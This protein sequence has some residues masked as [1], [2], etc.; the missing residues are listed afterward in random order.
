MNL[1]NSSRSQTNY[2]I[3]AMNHDSCSS[4]SLA[5]FHNSFGSVDDELSFLGD[6]STLDN[7]D[8]YHRQV[9]ELYEEWLKEHKVA[10]DD[11]I[12]ALMTRLQLECFLA[13]DASTSSILTDD[14]DCC[15]SLQVTRRRRGKIVEAMSEQ[16]E[17]NKDKGSSETK[18]ETPESK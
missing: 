18:A 3:T 14:Y 11:D 2:K 13:G 5:S 17:S 16:E 6:A 12:P 15:D 4:L 10:N 9:S 1:E 7:N 8:N